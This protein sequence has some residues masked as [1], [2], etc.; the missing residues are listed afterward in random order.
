MDTQLFVNQ[1]EFI[2]IKYLLGNL[3]SFL[4]TI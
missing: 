3:V 2:L 1:L 4:F